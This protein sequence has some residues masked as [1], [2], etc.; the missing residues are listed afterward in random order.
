MNSG[1]LHQYHT[2]IDEYLEKILKDMSKALIQKLI[3]ALDSV[4]KKLARYDE[5]TFFAQ[6]LSLAVRNL[7]EM[8][9]IHLVLIRNQ[10]MKMVRHM[11]HV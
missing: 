4:F 9:I 10:S 6:I 5:G 1:D 7:Y 3:S 8:I 2:R 11:F